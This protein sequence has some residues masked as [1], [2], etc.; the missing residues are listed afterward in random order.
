MSRKPEI[1]DYV[2][3]GKF[4]NSEIIDI[5]GNVVT[6]YDGH[7]LKWNDINWELVLKSEEI[8]FYQYD[9]GSL[10]LYPMLNILINA[11][12]E[13][14]KLLCMT[15]SELNDICKGNLTKEFIS[16]YGNLTEE[17][18]EGRVRN[19]VPAEIITYAKPQ[20]STWREFYTAYKDADNTLHLYISNDDE[21]SLQ[22]I[23]DNGNLLH[24][25]I[26]FKET[27]FN[28]YDYDNYKYLFLS[29]GN[30]IILKYILDKDPNIQFT[31]EHADYTV[32]QKNLDA[33]KFLASLDPPVYPSQ[34]AINDLARYPPENKKAQKMLNFYA[35]LNPPLL[36]TN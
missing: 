10:P 31:E 4:I 16:K 13:K 25:L 19:Y 30:P 23:F 11:D 26:F 1:G 14:F 2:K 15:N 32:G 18:Y 5:N 29:H 22:N 17:L 34:I 35:S 7:S 8:S 28:D 36:P 33:A 12:E 9:V 6:L 24:F 20:Y 21:E 3:I 27:N